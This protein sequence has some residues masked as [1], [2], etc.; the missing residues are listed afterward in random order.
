M[1]VS[2]LVS[3]DAI[4]ELPPAGLGCSA[5]RHLVGWAMVAG[6]CGLFL[7]SCYWNAEVRSLFNDGGMVARCPGAPDYW[8]GTGSLHICFINFINL[9]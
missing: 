8:P 3:L 6:G 7:C 2:D 4:S 5:S 1:T 9:I